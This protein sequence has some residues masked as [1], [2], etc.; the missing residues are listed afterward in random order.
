MKRALTIALAGL[1]LTACGSNTT[2]EAASSETTTNT[3]TTSAAPKALTYPSGDEVREGYPLI[4]NVDS[5]DTRVV[6]SFKGQLVEGQVVAVAP[7]VY[8]Q[9]NPVEP[10]LA[11][12]LKGP[13][14][15]DCT[16]IKKFFP[17]TS[18]SC[19]PGVL[20]GS[21]EPPL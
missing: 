9:Y 16:V 20:P 15:G 19:W 1:L 10:D 12:Y 21:E 8:M 18:N 11:Q 5:L 13:L 2:D 6:N 14:S 4:V 7:G 3:A 17:A